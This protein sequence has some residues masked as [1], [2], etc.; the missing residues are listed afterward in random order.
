MNQNVAD[1]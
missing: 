1:H